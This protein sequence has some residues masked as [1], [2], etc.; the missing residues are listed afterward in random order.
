MKILFMVFTAVRTSTPEDY[1]T[2][3]E[4]IGSGRQARWMGFRTTGNA[5]L[6]HGKNYRNKRMVYHVEC[7]RAALLRYE[8]KVLLHINFTC[9]TSIA[10]EYI[11]LIVYSHTLAQR[12]GL[13]QHERAKLKH[14]RYARGRVVPRISSCRV[15]ILLD[16]QWTLPIMDLS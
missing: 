11:W 6:S 15:K 14:N 3:F 13:L 7:S 12:Y 4:N 9:H 16:L 8:H 2:S 1:Y 5:R 10:C